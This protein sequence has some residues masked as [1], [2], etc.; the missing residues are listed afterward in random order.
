M[1]ISEAERQDWEKCIGVERFTSLEAMRR[2]LVRVPGGHDNYHAWECLNCGAWH[3]E[4]THAPAI[5]SH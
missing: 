2:D 5:G 3:V 4:T 1:P